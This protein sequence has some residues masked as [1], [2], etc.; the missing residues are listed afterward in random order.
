[1]A[2]I[3]LLLLCALLAATPG[4]ARAAE[5]VVSAAASLT[6][7][8]REVGAQYEREHPGETVVFNF[9][10]SD[11]LLAQIVR[12]APADV[13]ASADE[14][15]MDRAVAQRVI[16]PATRFDFARNRLVLVVQAGRPAPVSLAGLADASFRRI[17]IGNPAFVPAG[18]YAKAALERA[19][20]WAAVEPRAIPTQ[21]VRQSLD[22]VARGECD[23]GFVYATDAALMPDRLAIALDVPT[24]TPVRYPV[25]V[26]GA[27]RNRRLAE[28]FVD[29]L[30]GAAALAVLAR[31]GFAAP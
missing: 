12:G 15:A 14:E 7:A 19:G 1:M 6:N 27:S 21:N 10:A 28:G 5:L 2:R 8:F 26:V 9:A 31:H 24:A 17:A 18:R 30:R 23:A 25:A 13:F 22:Y 29:F 16:D 20:L 11:V 3:V 4:R